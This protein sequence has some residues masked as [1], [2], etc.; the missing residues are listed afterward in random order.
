MTK[1]PLRERDELAAR[2]FAL[3]EAG[4]SRVALMAIFKLSR[5]NV[6]NLIGYGRRLAAGQR[7]WLPLPPRR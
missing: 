5:G 6:V 1:L 3:H 4:W 2:V 7:P